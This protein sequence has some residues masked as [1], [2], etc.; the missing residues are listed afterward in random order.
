MRT[1]SIVAS[2]LLGTAFVALATD[3]AAQT[4][5]SVD[6]RTWR[7][8][9]DPNAGLNFEPVTTPG[10]WAWNIAGWLS[11]AQDPVTLRRAGTTDVASRPVINSLVADFTANVGIGQRAA[12]GLSLPTALYQNGTGGLPSTIATTGE[13]ASSAIG[14][15]GLHGKGTII[16]NVR[17]GLSA[18]FGLAALGTLTLP[19]GD[20]NSYIGDGSTTASIR[21]LAEYTL[22]VASVHASLGYKLRTA[23]NTW[24]DASIGGSTFGDEIPWAVGLSLRPGILSHSIDEDNR[25]TWEIGAHGWVPAGPVAPF[26]TGASSL[27]PVL[28]GASDRFAIGHYRDVYAVVGVEVGLSSAVGVPA[29]RGVAALGWSPREHDKDHDGIADDADL[30]PDDAEDHDG[31]DDADGCP[32][33]DADGDGILD[34]QDACPKVAGVWWNDPKK[35]GCP[36]PDTDGDGVPDPLDACVDVKGSPSDDPKKN[37]CP[38][39]TADMDDDGISDDMDRCPKDPEDIDGFEDEDG[40]PDLDNDADSIPDLKDACPN[41]KGD[42]HP[43]YHRHGCPNPDRDGDS[44]LN[45][46]DKCPDEAEVFNGIKDDDGCPDEGGT[47]LVSVDTKDPKLPIKLASAI[48]L[49][50]TPDVPTVDPASVF[51]LRALVLELNRHREWTLFIGARPGAGKADEAQRAAVNRAAAISSVVDKLALRDEA[52]EAVGWDAVKQQPGNQG[53]IGLM[54]VVAPPTPGTTPTPLP[55]APPTTTT[56]PPA[57]PTP[58]TTPNPATPGKKGGGKGGGHGGGKGGGHKKPGQPKP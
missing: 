45:D 21:I 2:F 11:Y 55:A 27:S 42:P 30:C 18:G 7:P 6:T 58:P 19:T 50:G 37:G 34:R 56:T 1:S 48:K 43:D 15:I 5:P 32:E 52:S 10:P 17:K 31:I 23:H 22:V 26:G 53:G 47:L 25:Q 40:C 38:T 54:F 29:I 16:S 14:D 51:T 28:V 13:V 39:E 33:D 44:Y 8:S 12:F 41:T 20:R 57:T 35:N 49:A 9:G 36:A 4:L 3:A 46:E 24:P